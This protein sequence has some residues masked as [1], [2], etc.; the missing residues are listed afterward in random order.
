MRKGEYIAEVE[1]KVPLN[2]A[3]NE[4]TDSDRAESDKPSTDDK[5]DND[6][7]DGDTDSD[8]AESDKP[9]T[10]DKQDN[11][12]IK[13]DTDSNST[14]SDKPSTDDKEDL[15]IDNPDL[16]KHE[17]LASIET[18]IK[19]KTAGTFLD[20]YYEVTVME[21]EPTERVLPN[22]EELSKMSKNQK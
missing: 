5:Q 20:D 4:D 3:I 13:E 11:D 15:T 18:N 9:S 12:A 17:N 6:A 10:D 2:A 7:I 8:R 16:M 21:E 14:E 22:P 1:S 19:M